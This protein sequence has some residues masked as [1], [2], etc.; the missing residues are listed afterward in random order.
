MAGSSGILITYSGYPYTPSSLMPDNGLANLAGALIKNG[1]E[2]LILDYNT[3]EI[4]KRLMPPDIRRDLQKLLSL[5]QKT[6]NDE[7]ID[8]L[9][10]INSR[11]EVHRE[12]EIYKIYKEI[13][14]HIIQRNVTFIGFKLWMGEG[15]SDSIKLADYIKKDYPNIKLYAGGPQVQIYKETIYKITK[16]FDAVAY[17]EGEE[18]I[19]FLARHSISE[20]NLKDI[21][22]IMYL[23]DDKIIVN[24]VKR[25]EDLD[26]IAYP[27]YDSEIYPA[28]GSNDKIKIFSI[29]ASRGCPNDCAFCVH[30]SISGSKIRKKSVNRILEEIKY[31]KQRY[32]S[33][34]FRF[35]GSYTPADV[36]LDLSKRLIEEKIN[37]TYTA[38]STLK[39]IKRDHIPILKAAGLFALYVGIESADERILK[40]DFEKW[41][42]PDRFKAI[43]KDLMDSGIFMIAS[44]IYPAPSEDAESRMKTKNYILELFSNPSR[45]SVTV[46]FP[47]LLPLGKWA[48]NPEKYGFKI[49]DFEEYKIIGMNYNIKQYLPHYLWDTLPYSINNKTHRELVLESSK[50]MEEIES[51]GV[52]TMI[53]DEAVMMAHFIDTKPLDFRNLM[54][55]TIFIG[56]HER[57]NEIVNEINKNLGN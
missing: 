52:L 37:I 53:L 12:K 48:E 18:I 22:N 10:K 24:P 44:F 14:E 41:F 29:D 2:V 20:M 5:L 45:A 4:V 23:E 27:V 7:L 47:G 55:N 49:N 11:I 33:R 15:F 51:H 17:G 8:D 46:H 28:C 1:H 38:F 42:Y 26:S 6:T 30:T 9:K 13:E 56:D 16:V 32:N 21:P 43:I 54:K 57:L 35:S 50:F 34:A 3:V 19:E 36:L 39:G 40:K 31:I 25:I